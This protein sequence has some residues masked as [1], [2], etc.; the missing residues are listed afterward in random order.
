VFFLPP[1]L[2]VLE[3]RLRGRGTDDDDAIRRRLETARQEIAQARWFDAW[4]VND[5]LDHAYALLR[6]A[7]L[8]ATLSPGLRPGL[9]DGIL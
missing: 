1:S 5:D 2:A 9:A 7:Y 4:L 3:A 8:F 6:A